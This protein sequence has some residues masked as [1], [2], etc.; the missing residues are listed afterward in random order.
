MFGH[1]VT[2]F[3]IFGFR[4]KVDLSWVFIALFIAWSLAQGFFPAVY[5]GLP[6]L[7]YWWMA[8]AGVI[9]LFFS[10]IFHELAHSL[11]AR[12][13]G[14]EIRGITLWVFGGVAEM[15]GEPKAPR[16]EFW[17]AIAGPVSSLVLAGLFEAVSALLKEV[18]GAA[19]L[20]AVAGY[21]GLLNL[22]LAVFNLMPAFPLDGGRVL[23]AALWH[24]RGNF[25]DATRI[26]TRSG[27]FFGFLLMAAGAVM[28]LRGNLVGGIWWVLIG[29][30]LRGAAS[31]SYFQT[32]ATRALARQT[33]AQFMTRNPVTVGPEVTLADLVERYMYRHHVDLFPVVRDGALLGAVSAAQVKQVPRE[34]WGIVRVSAVAVPAGADNTIDASAGAETALA[35]MR[36]S[37][38]GRLLVT[39]GGRLAG[40]VALKDLLNYLT[41][42][43]D[44]D[45]A[46]G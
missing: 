1:S 37:G 43:F 33:V 11:V 5:E 3:E 26:A 45:G 12:L 16:A 23:R 46:P 13:F 34:E 36:K 4:V 25:F 24:I 38:N 8:V 39:E 9:G 41:L 27:V 20:A 2:L 19:A 14:L 35:L 10:L 42:R 21:L 29:L 31:A 32:S 18:D 44:L 6:P 30:F 7:T 17:M 22:V 40:V 15:E 28:M